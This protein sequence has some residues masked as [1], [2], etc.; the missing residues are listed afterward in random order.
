MPEGLI[1]LYTY[2]PKKDGRYPI[3]IWYRVE[4]K[5]VRKATGYSAAMD[6][7]DHKKN[8]PNRKHPGG[9]KLTDKLRKMALEDPFR[10]DSF[11]HFGEQLIAE[12][13]A[14]GKNSN[15][16]AYRT[17]VERFKPFCNTWPT[18]AH[19]VA[20]KNALLK[21]G[22]A[23]NSTAVYLRTLRAIWNE[24]ERRD[25]I[26]SKSPFK[27]GLIQQQE[28]A[29]R[30]LTSDQVAALKNFEGLPRYKDR[31]RMLWLVLASMR[32]LDVIDVMAFTPERFQDGYYIAQREKTGVPLKIWVPPIYHEF[33]ARG[34]LH[35]MQQQT[36][37]RRNLIRELT[38][39][40]HRL[41]FALQFKMARH[42]F[43]T[44]AKQVG[45]PV[46]VIR[47]MLGHSGKGVTHI[48]LGR[49]DQEIIDDWHR[50]AL[51][52]LGLLHI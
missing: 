18:Y 32:G 41:G 4:G 44:A 36:D 48:Y 35:D 27:R 2:R 12:L 19:L 16:T 30:F 6:E 8:L 11:A 42:T 49:Y 20:F 9:Q 1:R 37:P 50:R 13:Q 25:L 28:T 22:C 3:V 7:W 21:Q 47:E 38:D 5:Q 45:C 23:I 24:A 52:F 10:P 33:V 43:A 46:D 26:E 31:A 39:V 15:A 29:K 34:Y 40:G 14:R 51:I 17:A